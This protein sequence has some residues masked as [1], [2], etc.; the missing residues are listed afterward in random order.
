MIGRQARHKYKTGGLIFEINSIDNSSK[1]RIK[2]IKPHKRNLSS[3]YQFCSLI[4]RL[5]MSIK[6][7]IHYPSPISILSSPA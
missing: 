3:A 2:L 7:H 6:L 4:K 5:V 1:F